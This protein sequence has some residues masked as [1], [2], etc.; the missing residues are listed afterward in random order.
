[1]N[2]ALD[3]IFVNFYLKNILYCE[4]FL[5]WTCIFR[6]EISCIYVAMYTICMC[7]YMYVCIFGFILYSGNSN[8]G[9]NV[10]SLLHL[11]NFVKLL[12]PLWTHSAFSFENQMHSLLSH[13][14]AT[15][16]IGKQ[17]STYYSHSI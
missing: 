10:H 17:V 13:S 15:H 6:L 14:H 16:G 1:M 2:I 7:L 4:L 3:I 9:I 12:G 11:T 5:C 8:C